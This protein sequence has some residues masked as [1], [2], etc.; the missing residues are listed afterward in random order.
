MSHVHFMEMVQ[1]GQ[2]SVS[3][4]SMHIYNDYELVKKPRNRP[5][6]RVSG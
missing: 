3:G 4:K 1:V 5:R 6:N 2:L